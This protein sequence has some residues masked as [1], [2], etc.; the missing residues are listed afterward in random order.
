MPYAASYDM[1]NQVRCHGYQANVLPLRSKSRGSVRLASPDPAAPPELRFNYMSHPDDWIDMRCC[2]RLTREIFAQ[3]AFDPYRGAELSPGEA[4]RTDDEIDDFVR[5]TAQTAFHPAGS[6]K[7]GT[8]AMA[9]VDPCNR[10]HGIDG[11]R[12]VDSSV[13]PTVVSGN[14]NAPTVM[15]AEKAADA[16]R[17]REPLPSSDAPAYEAPG[18]ERTQ[19]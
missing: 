15:I 2:V 3:P 7:M 19:R 10:V 12:V 14:L 4:V 13:M 11:L 8:D 1:A 5:A 9:V 16:I 6:C 17:G 18:W